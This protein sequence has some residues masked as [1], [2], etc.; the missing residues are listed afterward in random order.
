[1][2]K[3]TRKKVAI[4]SL[5]VLMAIPISLLYYSITPIAGESVS[6]TVEIPIG[7]G[8][9]QIVDILDEAGIVK[10]RPLFYALAILKNARK[11]FRAGEYEI[12]SSMT[13]SEIIDRLVKGIVK[14]YKVTIPE[15]LNIR[16]VAA[17]L[18]S[19]RLVDREEF[20]KLATDKQF[21]VSLN[22]KAPSVEGFLYPNTYNFTRSMGAKEIIKVMVN[23]FWKVY[24]PEMR[25]RTEALGMTNTQLITLASLIGK[26][27]G[28]KEE[29]TLIS[30][31]FYNRLRKGMKLQSDPT[32]VYDLDNFSGSVKKSHLS[33]MS[34]YNTYIIEGLP[35]GPIANPGVDSIQAALYPASV[36]YLYFVSNRNGSHLFSITFNSHRE[37]IQQFLKN[38]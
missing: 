13:P 4:V 5:L 17:R 28:F 18:V 1:M 25:K 24:T 2:K 7:A 23:Q 12:I 11:R 15:D 35:P 9:P 37:A 20:L 10:N 32:A 33:R 34:P 31:V 14:G 36:E 22:I 38:N 19:Q 3:S 8:F 30:A 6:I 16:E 21:L 26:E 27:S 29:K